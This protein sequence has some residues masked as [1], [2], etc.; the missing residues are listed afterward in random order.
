MQEHYLQELR[1]EKWRLNGNPVRTLD[2][3]CGLLAFRRDGCALEN[4]R[5][6]L[7]RGLHVL[8]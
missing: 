5:Q 7:S 4:E 1:R 8:V 6:A 3:A 2:D